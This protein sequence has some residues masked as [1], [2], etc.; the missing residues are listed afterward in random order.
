MQC[1]WGCQDMWFTRQ[2]QFVIFL[3]L[4]II[5][6][7]LQMEVIQRYVHTRQIYT[8]WCVRDFVN[9]QDVVS[10]SGSMISSLIRMMCWVKHSW[11]SLISIKYYHKTT[12]IYSGVITVVM[13]LHNLISMLCK[14]GPRREWVYSDQWCKVVVGSTWS[15]VTA[16]PLVSNQM[17][18]TFFSYVKQYLN[19]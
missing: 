12:G 19:W 3:N 2:Y 9:P 11:L 17:S 18:A 15:L 16:A 7:W 8:A 14:W 13:L 10:L 5:I 4:C 6:S 1:Q